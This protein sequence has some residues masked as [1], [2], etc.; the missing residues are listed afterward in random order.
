MFQVP[1]TKNR[2][3]TPI[4]ANYCSLKNH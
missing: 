4:S 1:C 2:E 3:P